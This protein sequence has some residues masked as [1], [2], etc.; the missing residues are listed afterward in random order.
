MRQVRAAAVDQIDAR[1]PVFLGN[2]LRA[3]ML[4]DRQRIIGAALHR[5]VVADD[6]A[7]RP[8]TRPMIRGT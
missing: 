8:D 6:H 2:L 5:R 4:L 3:Q 7:L 1:Q